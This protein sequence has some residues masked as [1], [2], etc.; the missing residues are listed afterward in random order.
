MQALNLTE[1][2]KTLLQWLVEQVR[3]GMLNEE[4]IWFVWS[5]DGASLVG[6]QG[7]VPE[8]KTTTLNALHSSG[9]LSCD[10]SRPNQYKCALTNRAYEAVDS[11]FGA[12]NLSATLHLIPLTEVQHLDP[13]LWDRCRFSLS[14]GG[15]DP[16]AWDKAVRTA[17]VVLEE[18]LRKLGKTEAINPDATGEG[19]VNII[20]AGKNPVL[21][22]KLDD[23]QLKAYRDLYAGMMAVFR[24]LYAH[25]VIDPSPEVGGAIIVFIDLLLKTLDDID[26]DSNGGE[27]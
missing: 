20:F 10:R 16:K 13:E 23:K 27:T 17:T 3:A 4:E 22:S 7:N 1:T 6:Y 8:V 19:L 25:R 14:S 18:R 24:N 2:Q 26:W 21:S 9:C 15:D 5:F 12:P 11:N